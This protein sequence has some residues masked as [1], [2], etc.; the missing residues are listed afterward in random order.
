MILAGEKGLGDGYT[1]GNIKEYSVM[2]IAEAF[3]GPVELVD[4]YPG[5][6]ES[7][8]AP[9]KA[10]EELGWKTTVDI[11]DYI[12]EFVRKHPRG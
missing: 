9:S 10:R 11:I 3:G 4:G 6:Q 2:D 12:K 1:L 7:G 5:R 8:E